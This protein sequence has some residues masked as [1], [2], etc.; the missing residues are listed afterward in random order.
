VTAEKDVTG[1]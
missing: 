1:D